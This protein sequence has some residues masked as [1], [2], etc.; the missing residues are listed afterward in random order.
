MLGD[1]N[2]VDS[3]LSLARELRIAD[4]VEHINKVPI[5][6]VK[7]FMAEADIGISPHNAGPFGSL[8]FSNKIVDFMTQGI[9]VVSSRT[10][11]IEKYIPEEALFYFEP[12]NPQELADQI[13]HMHTNPSLVQDKIR[14]SRD[15]VTKYNWQAERD[16]I[17]SF[18]DDLVA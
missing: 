4:R 12:D 2:R 9:P 6:Q 8:Y 13:L 17:V 15:L 16:K 1:G 14:I 11:T 10:Y 18:Y 3:V 5:E 7:R